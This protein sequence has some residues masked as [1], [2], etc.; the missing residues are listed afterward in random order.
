M[1]S[2]SG[3]LG[4]AAAVGLPGLT[5]GGPDGPAATGGRKRP[6]QTAGGALSA[7]QRAD[8]LGGG[9]QRIQNQSAVAAVRNKNGA[10]YIKVAASQ[11]WN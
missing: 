10:P 8:R 4:S 1:L 11:V 5:C 2:A 6:K 7:A 9:Y 3:L